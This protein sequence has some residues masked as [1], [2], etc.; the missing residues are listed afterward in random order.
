MGLPRR[1]FSDIPMKVSVKGSSEKLVNGTS[2]T[3]TVKDDPYSGCDS[4]K[5]V[6]ASQWP[7]FPYSVNKIAE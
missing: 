3:G 5:K 6:L 7:T 2:E 1:I 4:K